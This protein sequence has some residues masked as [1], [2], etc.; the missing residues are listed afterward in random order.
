[1]ALA[2][3]P[4]QGPQRPSNGEITTEDDE[5]R[6]AEY[7]QDWTRM[8]MVAGT[9]VALAEGKEYES[10]AGDARKIGFKALSKADGEE[11]WQTVA[12]TPGDAR[13]VAKKVVRSPLPLSDLV[14]FAELGFVVGE[15]RCSLYPGPRTGG[16]S[17]TRL[18]SH[19]HL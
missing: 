17:A 11:D 13:I 7:L 12:V 15:R 10:L 8:H 9:D 5:K 16:A 3:K 14:M 1:M 19:H 6:N 18:N 4:H 2:R